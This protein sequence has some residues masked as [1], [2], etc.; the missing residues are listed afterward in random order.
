MLMALQVDVV[1]RGV[2]RIFVRDLIN[3][4][5]HPVDPAE[6]ERLAD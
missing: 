1:L 5:S 3:P 4:G 2:N 6:A